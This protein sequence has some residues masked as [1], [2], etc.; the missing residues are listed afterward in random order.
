MVSQVILPP[1]RLPTYVTGVGPLVRMRP[2]VYQ[3][4]VTFRELS[5][6]KFTYELFFWSRTSLLPRHY[7]VTGDRAGR[8]ASR[9]IYRILVHGVHY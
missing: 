1:E 8:R 3:Q 6:T 5:I 2:F 4:I 7:H 9:T